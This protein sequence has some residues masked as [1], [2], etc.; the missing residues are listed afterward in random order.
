M[1]RASTRRSHRA[2]IFKQSDPAFH[3]LGLPKAQPRLGRWVVFALLIGCA[4][5]LLFVF[6]TQ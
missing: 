2:D 4:V 6:L 3:M 5:S 1:S